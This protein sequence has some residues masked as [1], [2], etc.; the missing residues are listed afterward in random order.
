MKLRVTGLFAIV[1]VVFLGVQS[2]SADNLPKT[3]AVT[4]CSITPKDLPASG[5]QLTV[6]VRVV[7]LNGVF[8]GVTAVT[9]NVNK[10]GEHLFTGSLTKVSGTA[11]DG[12]WQ[13]VFSVTPNHSLGNYR[14]SLFPISDVQGVSD[15]YIHCDSEIVNFG[16]AS[17]GEGP[18]TQIQ[19]LP[20][21]TP[22]VTITAQ[23]SP[24]PTVT[25]TAQPS[26]SNV[27]SIGTLK[28]QIKILQTRLKKICA[29]KPKP[30]GC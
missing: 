5:G 22:T 25:I 1:G 30:K 23:P 16:V 15:G 9:D 20:T 27:E 11:Q 19:T 4:H 17:L 28:A 10:N 6:Q 8:S 13:S 26:N 3:P 2:V 21:P 18:S 24:A 12:V 14:L 29:I 7:S